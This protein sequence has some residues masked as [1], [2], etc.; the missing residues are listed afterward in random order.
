MID[1][2][3]FTKI[4]ESDIRPKKIF[5]SIDALHSSLID[6]S[7]EWIY[8]AFSLSTWRFWWFHNGHREYLPSTKKH[9]ANTLGY[10]EEDIYMIT[11][12]DSRILARAQWDTKLDRLFAWEE[13]ETY[14]TRKELVS[15]LDEV[16][17]VVELPH[18]TELFTYES[19]IP[20]PDKKAIQVLCEKYQVPRS[21]LESK[22]FW[23][24]RWNQPSW[25]ES[26]WVVLSA[27]LNMKQLIQEIEI[28]MV[29]VIS[30]HDDYKQEAWLIS[31]LAGLDVTFIT[32][33]PTF[34]FTDLFEKYGREGV[35]KYLKREEYR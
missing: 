18:Y 20:L 22:A 19:W 14:Y 7:K 25:P 8:K 28:P 10:K 23:Y 31:E 33:I 4:V 24:L 16:N 13:Q 9:T 12:I 32:N 2:K 30:V 5:D 1:K 17:A 6:I 26:N 27:Y 29:R 34:H 3:E 21:I 15:T 35:L 11:W